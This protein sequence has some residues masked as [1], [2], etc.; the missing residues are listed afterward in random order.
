MATN[1][2]VSAFPSLQRRGG[3][4]IKKKFPFRKRRGRGGRSQVA[5]GAATP[6]LQ[7]G[8]CALPISGRVG[9]RTCTVPHRLWPF[10]W[11]QFSWRALPPGRQHAWDSTFR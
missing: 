6:P 9:G 10:Y 8:E 5:S 7:G 1:R 11:E 2:E 3:R 4:A